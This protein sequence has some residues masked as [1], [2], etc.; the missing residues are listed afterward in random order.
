M[1][2]HSVCFIAR[3]RRFGCPL[4]HS[5]SVEDERRRRPPPRR[6]VAPTSSS[7]SSLLSSAW[8]RRRFRPLCRREAVN[9]YA[10]RC[11][12]AAVSSVAAAV[13]APTF[14]LW[15]RRLCRVHPFLRDFTSGS[16]AFTR[17]RLPVDVYTLAFTRWRL[18]VGVYPLAF[19]RWR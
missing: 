2:T 13:D 4:S 7:S 18:P 10:R 1:P 17:W 19:T 6:C 14:V 9:I 5:V 12:S 3:S 16:L 15:L 11:N 8:S